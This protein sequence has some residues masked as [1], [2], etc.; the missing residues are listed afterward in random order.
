MSKYGLKVSIDPISASDMIIQQGFADLLHEDIISIDEN[1]KIITLVFEKYYMRV[2]GRAGLVVIIDNVNGNTDIR[3]ITTGT[4]RGMIF[5]FDW[6]ASDDFASSAVS[7]LSD[8]IVS[9]REL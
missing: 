8:Y 4:S 2:E 3:V 9:E 7:C 6:G 1:K 5:D